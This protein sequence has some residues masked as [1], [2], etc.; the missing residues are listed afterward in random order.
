MALAENT[1]YNSTEGSLRT[2]WQVDLNDNLNSQFLQH[3][4]RA[5]KFRELISIITSL[6]TLRWHDTTRHE[7]KIHNIYLFLF[8]LNNIEHFKNPYVQSIQPILTCIHSVKSKNVFKVPTVYCSCHLSYYKGNR[9]QILLFGC[10]VC[11]F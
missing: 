4:K 1:E 9:S 10:G 11:S 6:C 3:L 2:T 8:N 7:F 5:I